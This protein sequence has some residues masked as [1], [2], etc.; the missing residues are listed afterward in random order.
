[1]KDEEV[2]GVGGWKREVTSVEERREVEGLR[3]GKS[4]A[5]EKG[6]KF[7]LVINMILN[8]KYNIIKW[9]FHL[10]LLEIISFGHTNTIAIL[11]NFV[12]I[13]LCSN[14]PSQN[15]SEFNCLYISTQ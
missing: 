14:I 8:L 11:C 3:E 2:S 15:C 5:S 13:L 10:F 6:T 1:M 12:I 4:K 7:K 9:I